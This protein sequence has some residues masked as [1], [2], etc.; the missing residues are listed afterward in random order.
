MKHLTTCLV[1]L[2]LIVNQS[3][4]GY[5]QPVFYHARFLPREPGFCKAFLT[6]ADFRFAGGSTTQ[7]NDEFG[8]PTASEQFKR[9]RLYTIIFDI[10]K[11]L[12]NNLFFA[13]NL[14]IYRIHVL[15]EPANEFDLTSVSNMNLTTGFTFNYEDTDIF[16]F[17]D[18]TIETGIILPSAKKPSQS[19]GMPFRIALATGLY[20]WLT[21]G[22]EIS[23]ASFFDSN[24]G[25]LWSLS[26]YMKADH[27]IQGLSILFGYSHS[28]QKKT[29]IPWSMTET[30]T[31]WDMD[32]F[33][34]SFSYDTASESC[35][36]AP[37]LEVFY[38]HVMN[39]K[40]CIENSL[41]GINLGSDF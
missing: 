19:V 9:Y 36:F 25:P 28:A 34:F 15:E 40:N 23:G 8:T 20:D 32:T 1:F 29:P 13:A 6:S 4:N 7:R 21:L 30:L 33:H 41:F 5:D 14:P 16:D 22:G 35:P 2:F 37:R 11:N 26:W 10:R 24:N 3:I 18:A 38:N 17:F 12:C 39:G 27:F 31:H